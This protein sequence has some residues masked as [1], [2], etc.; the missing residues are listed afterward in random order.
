MKIVGYL[1]DE[2]RKILAEYELNGTEYSVTR[3][4]AGDS[5]TPVSSTY[6]YNSKQSL[7]VTVGTDGEVRTTLNM[8]S[9]S[10]PYYLNEIALYVKQTGGSEK[11]FKIFKLSEQ[12]Y[13]DNTQPHTLTFT[14]KDAELGGNPGDVELMPSGCVSHEELSQALQSLYIHDGTTVT[15]SVSSPS[16]FTSAVENIPKTVDCDYE[17]KSDTSWVPGFTLEN[18]GG[19]GR[20]IISNA[21]DEGSVYTILGRICVKNCT[22]PLI[23]KDFEHMD[24]SNENLQALWGENCPFIRYEKCKVGASYSGTDIFEIKNSRLEYKDTVFNTS[25]GS[26]DGIAGERS[27]VQFDF[28]PSGDQTA[29]DMLGRKYMTVHCKDGSGV[30]LA[31]QLYD[32]ST[33]YMSYNMSGGSDKIGRSSAT[34]PSYIRVY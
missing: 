1:T 17:I 12:I 8:A 19:G 26:A 4:A 5:D 9:A 16:D 23:I 6:I 34:E 10:S 3:A 14:F 21:G 29:S 11:F 22:V 20:I 33:S 31:G 27:F 25:R 15:V 30:C 7:S 13:I 2:G 28:T 32:G 24:D 18:I